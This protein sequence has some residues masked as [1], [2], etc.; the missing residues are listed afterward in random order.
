MR[1]RAKLCTFAGVRRPAISR[2]KDEPSVGQICA[3]GMGMRLSGSGV[4]GVVIWVVIQF[5]WSLFIRMILHNHARAVK[6]NLTL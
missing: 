3:G 6:H 2:Y 1:L 5:E 4:K